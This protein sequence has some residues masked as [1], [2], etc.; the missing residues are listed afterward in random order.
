MLSTWHPEPADNGR[1]QRTSAMLRALAKQY[2]VLLVSLL[3]PNEAGKIH[4]RVDSAYMQVVLPLPTFESRSFKGLIGSVNR[5]PRSAIATWSGETAGALSNLLE[6]ERV[7]AAIGTD[8]RTL[9][10]LANLPAAMVKVIDEPDVSPFVVESDTGW[11]SAASLR[12]RLRE[13]KYRNLLNDDLSRIDASVVAST[14]EVDALRHMTPADDVHVIPNAIERVPPFRWGPAAARPGSLL[15]TGSLSYEP[16][17][18]AVAYLVREVFPRL[19]P[20]LPNA[21][22]VVTGTIPESIPSDIVSE[23]VC[24]TGRLPYLDTAYLHSRVF[25]APVWSGTGTRIK[26]IEAM[27]YGMPIVSTTKGAEGLPV[28]SGEHLLIADNAEDFASA[29]LTLCSDPA[30][31][32]RLGAAGR[33]LVRTRFTWERQGEQLR[34]LIAGLLRVRKERR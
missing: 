19:E 24:L 8:L 32:L 12:D 11:L 2:D 13:W 4:D 14:D 6:S 25:V 27:A 16:N 34:D 20:Q 30:L 17:A 23:R 10:Y 1:K 29:V 33:E 15:Y 21:Q 7:Q 18:E 5:Y 26:L 22:V 3:A 9:R 28:Q 31:S